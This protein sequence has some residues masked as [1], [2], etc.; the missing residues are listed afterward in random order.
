M[1]G[2]VV[3]EALLVGGTNLTFELTA[4]ASMYDLRIDR[5]TLTYP[6]AT[7]PE[8]GSLVLLG[9]ALAGLNWSRRRKLT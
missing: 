8:P 9:V 2:L 6:S 1:A 5:L 4:T 3:P 7:V